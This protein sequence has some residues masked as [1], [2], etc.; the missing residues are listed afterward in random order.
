MHIA[1]P[2]HTDRDT[3]K[4]RVEQRLDQLLAQ[5]QHYLSD[6]EKRWEGDTLHFSGAA[7]GFKANGTVAITDTEAILDGKLP[8]IARLCEPRI[9]RALE[10][11]AAA[12]FG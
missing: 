2:H 10:G 11:D 4:R 12:M 5:Y 1:V 6:H 3:A 9:R 7:R 8:L